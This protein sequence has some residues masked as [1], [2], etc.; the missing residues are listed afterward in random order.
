VGPA[1]HRTEGAPRPFLPSEIAGAKHIHDVTR[2][3]LLE[4]PDH[5]KI[6]GHRPIRCACGC[7]SVGT[8]NA[9]VRRNA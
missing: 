6:G 7:A 3:E 2:A 4:Q 8:H 5:P 9:A 1:M